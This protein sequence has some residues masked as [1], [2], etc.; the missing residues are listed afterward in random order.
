MIRVLSEVVKQNHVLG[1]AASASAS[2]QL[3]EA[4]RHAVRMATHDWLVCL[5]SDAAGEDEETTRLI[6]RLCA[7]NDV[8][9]VYVHDPLE[10]DLPD[11]G[12]AVFSAGFG[13]IEIDSSSQNLRG[14]FAREHAD[15]RSRLA[16][17]SRHRAI[18]ILPISTSLDVRYNSAN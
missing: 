11:V 12:S 18:P 14:Q 10:H 15:W 3:N 5:V 13:Q 7:H 4:R 9:A 2:G 8:L 1:Q 17:L 16:D 6:T